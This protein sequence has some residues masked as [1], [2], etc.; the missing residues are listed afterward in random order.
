[1]GEFVSKGNWRPRAEFIERSARTTRYDRSLGGLSALLM[2]LG[3]LL[4]IGYLAW[5]A[6]DFITTKTVETLEAEITGLREQF[7]LS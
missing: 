2:V 5:H 7:Q 3:P 1:M 4:L 6:N